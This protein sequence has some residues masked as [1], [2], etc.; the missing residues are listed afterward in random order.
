[1]RITL[2]IHDMVCSVETENDELDSFEM[3]DLFSRLMVAAG[4]PA[5]VV[6][7]EGVEQGVEL[8]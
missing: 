1:M 5:C 2:E 6:E 7:A 8:A 3:K 4:Y